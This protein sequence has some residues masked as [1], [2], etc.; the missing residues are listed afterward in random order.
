[1]SRLPFILLLCA[2]LCPMY[3]TCVWA[4]QS[5]QTVFVSIL[6]EVDFVRRIG[7]SRVRVFPLVLPGQSPATYAPT[8]QQMA[9][10]SQANLYFR[11]G[12]PFENKL[13]PK[14]QQTIPELLISD[15]RSGI[16]RI[17]RQS[18]TGQ[19][20]DSHGHGAGDDPHIWLDPTL[21]SQMATGIR[22]ALIAIDPGGTDVY[23]QNCIKFQT[24]LH[25][26]NQ[27]LLQTLQPLHGQTIYVFHPAYAYFCRAYGL[28]QHPIAPGGKIPGGRHLADFID[29]A[30]RDQVK[31]IFIQPQFSKKTAATIAQA[32][33]ATL[34]P[35]D[36]LAE[37]Y[38]KNMTSIGENIKRML[39]VDDTK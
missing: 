34:V 24:Q 37:D 36:P 25:E 20:H 35:M 10:L 17:R 11:I 28:K 15:L 38:L 3:C 1:M 19:R 33:G 9:A 5:T 7:G 8:P 2:L 14:L 13:I 12:V 6:P 29:Q 32:I 23:R 22:D 39:Y 4:A 30:R 21:V 18:E 31:I 26:L 16:K 27:Q